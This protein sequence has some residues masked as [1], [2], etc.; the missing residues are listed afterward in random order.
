MKTPV[1]VLT[2]THNEEANLA[3]CLESVRWAA[4]VFVVDSYSTDRTVEIARALGA[5]V[6]SHPYEGYTRQQNW[7]LDNLPFRQDW[8]LV[9]DADERIPPPLAAEIAAAVNTAGNG[10]EGFYL[11]RRFFFLGNWLKHGGLSPSWVL[12]LFKRQA[13][14]FEDRLANMHV[15]LKGQTGQLMQP[16]EHRDQRPLADWIAKHNLYADLMAEE[17]RQER[18]GEGYQDSIPARFWGRQAE[19][20]R[21]I[22]LHLWNRLP[23]LLRPFLLFFRNYFFKGGFL[24]GRPGLIYHVLWSLWFPFLIDAKILEKQMADAEARQADMTFPSQ[25]GAGNRARVS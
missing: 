1:C 4:E 15:V 21:W 7:A 12:R 20:K 23:L 10:L 14:R 2:L 13:G 25:V 22:K 17:Y 19:R 5:S 16:F 6:Y 8:I 3:S 24:D 11:N 18:F 9:L